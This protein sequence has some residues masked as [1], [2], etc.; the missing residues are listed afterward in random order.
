LSGREPLTKHSPMHPFAS[1]FRKLTGRTPSPA[2]PEQARAEP[3][4]A[5][6]PPAPAPSSPRPSDLAGLVAAAAASAAAPQYRRFPGLPGSDP[7]SLARAGREAAAR[8]A[9]SSGAARL[10]ALN[11]DMFL[12]RDF[13]SADECARLM[14]LVDAGVKP[15]TL[16]SDH[17]NDRIRTSY[18]CKLPATEPVVAEVERR[19][20]DLL[21]LPLSHSE[22]VQGQRYTAGQQF[23]MHND[24]FAGGQPYSEAVAREGGQ[25]TWT[26]MIFLNRPGSGGCTNFPRALVKIEPEPG[27]LLTW[28]NNDRQG[29]SNPWSHHEG[30]VVEAGVKYVLTKW[31]REREWRGSAE[32]DALRA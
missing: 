1:L 13:L 19:I 20:A 10:P 14:E 5:A 9:S 29:L 22:T 4:A 31:F 6:P 12:V 11:L 8:L 26:A 17:G 3:V 28:N 18:T 30:M 21:G 25:R 16:L 27:A 32:S 15:S 7:Q 24:Y 23:R 2:V